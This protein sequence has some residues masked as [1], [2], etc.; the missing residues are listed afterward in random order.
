VPFDTPVV[1]FG[2]ATI[3]V[4][5]EP[6]PVLV[7][8]TPALRHQGLRGVTGLDPRRGMLFVFQD[9]SRAAFTMADTLIPLDIA[10]FAADGS[11]VD[12]LLMTPCPAEPCP[13]Y[14]AA[15]QYRYTLEVPAGGFEGVA[16]LRLDPGSVPG[17]S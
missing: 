9:D 15:G 16:D 8:D 6:W 3:I 4:G 17:G 10:F 7:A 2:E 12:R 13:D 14:Q 1:G 5:G 11:L